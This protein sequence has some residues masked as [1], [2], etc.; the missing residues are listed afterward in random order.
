ML[1]DLPLST[2]Q[3][4]QLARR[5]N[6]QELRTHLVGLVAAGA[7]EHPSTTQEVAAKL[8]DRE[9]VRTSRAMPFELFALRHRL[10][11]G[12]SSS[13][14]RRPAPAALLEAVDTALDLAVAN[15]SPIP[16]SVLVCPDVSGSMRAPFGAD[17]N[18]APAL[19]ALDVA[20]LA[21]VAIA[22]RNW[23]SAF[24][25][26]ANGFVELPPRASTSKPGSVRGAVDRVL[27][28]P[29]R[30]SAQFTPLRW[31]TQLGTV[32]DVVILFSDDPSWG[33]PTNAGDGPSYAKRAPGLAEQWRFLRAYHPTA[34]L[35]LVSFRPSMGAGRTPRGAPRSLLDSGNVLEI[36][37]F[38]D[39]AFDVIARF[40]SGQFPETVDADS[41]LEPFDVRDAQ[42]ARR[43]LDDGR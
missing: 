16:G 7:F 18:T 19:R 1:T 24:A 39:E 20:A 33:E 10:M 30:V 40:A 11:Q 42:K 23:R 12:Q 9:A 35:V 32:P 2:R 41:S 6:H 21:S 29:P 28:T 5:M 22:R 8:T 31:L 36:R 15:L 14:P 37:G 26:F 4:S 34:K 3:W 43:V 38:S 25:P 27:S 17:E 13:H